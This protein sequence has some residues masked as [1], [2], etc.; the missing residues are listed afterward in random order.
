MQLLSL[1]GMAW[2]RVTVLIAVAILGAGAAF[3]PHPPLAPVRRSPLDLG[4][5][6]YAAMYASFAVAGPPW[7]WDYWSIWGLKGRTFFEHGGIDFRFLAAPW[8]AFAHPDYPQLVPLNLAFP[9]VLA[10]QWDD[11]WLGALFAAWALAAA[12]VVRDLAA[13]DS[14][15][16]AAA[17][18]TVAVLALVCSLYVGLAETPLMA[19]S[20]TGLLFTRR[21]LQ[22]ETWAR[23]P[24]AILLGLAASA[25]NEGLALL[26]AVAL[27]IVCSARVAALVIPAGAA[28]IA[29][30]WL[31]ARAVA[32]LPSALV[33]PGAFSRTLE[34]LPELGTIAV[35]LAERT[36]KPWLWL[37]I[38]VVLLFAAKHERFLI[39]V[40]LA[41]L[42]FFLA[43]YF[44]A[45]Q[46]VIWH[47][48]T[49]W[50]R[51]SRQLLPPA[52][53]AALA[54]LAMRFRG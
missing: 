5:A 49:S 54:A 14:A 15:P 8:N 9:A 30:P 10:G 29:A 12:L 34:R 2:S 37:A 36:D 48:E 16:Y 32:D 53:Y 50:G 27:A 20:V 7:L 39:I 38:A 17:A 4:I 41:Q 26:V 43:V 13:R 52:A 23:V 45:P 31:I 33:A 47:V 46:D 19:F 42:A 40:V 44:A 11:R 22:G 21:A 6:A 3:L 28:L 35:K 1:A 18:A 24:A 51:L 25:K